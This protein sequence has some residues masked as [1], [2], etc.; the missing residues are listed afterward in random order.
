MGNAVCIDF[1]SH[2]SGL[3]LNILIIDFCF[4][5]D[6]VA[7]KGIKSQ[8]K[9]SRLILLAQVLPGSLCLTNLI[10]Y[11]FICSLLMI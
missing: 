9:V 2:G 10:R 1:M 4:R 7:L 6:E 8:L 5:S 3:N 11:A